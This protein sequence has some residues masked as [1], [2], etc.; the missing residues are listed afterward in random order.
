MEWRILSIHQWTSSA[1]RL[2]HATR[3]QDSGSR[4]SATFA[5]VPRDFSFHTILVERNHNVNPGRYP[6]CPEAEQSVA[7]S[8]VQ[9]FEGTHRR[10]YFDAI[11]RPPG[12]LAILC[13]LARGLPEGFPQ[14]RRGEGGQVPPSM[15]AVDPAVY[16]HAGPKSTE[17][18]TYAAPNKNKINTSSQIVGHPPDRGLCRPL[19]LI[20]FV[21]ALMSYLKEW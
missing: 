16:Y 14:H 4:L 17:R 12:D 3:L 7:M 18:T 11:A 8:K 1:T 9:T 20:F 15:S 19:D 10:A 6:S 2:S 5:R 13:W 21:V